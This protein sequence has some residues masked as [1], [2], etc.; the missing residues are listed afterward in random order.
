ME[1]CKAWAS[2]RHRSKGEMRWGH[3]NVL[4]TRGY[5]ETVC[6]GVLG[7]A[8]LYWWCLSWPSKGLTTGQEKLA[9]LPE[10]TGLSVGVTPPGVPGSGTPKAPSS[11]PEAP[12]RAR[13]S[14]QA[15][16]VGRHGQGL[17]RRRGPGWAGGWRRLG[18]PSWAAPGEPP[19]ARGARRP[20][21]ISR[22]P[23]PRP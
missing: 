14:P 15:T 19:P 10:P 2:R 13:G 20:R 21:A 1:L 9:K 23:S 3:S 11:I 22:P 7:G 18:S 4:R 8:L 5:G 6:P 17:G 16:G 12:G